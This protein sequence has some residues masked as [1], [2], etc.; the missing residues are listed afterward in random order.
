MKHKVCFFAQ[1]LIRVGERMEIRVDSNEVGIKVLDPISN[2]ILDSQ[3]FPAI[4]SKI[5]E[6][7]DGSPD[8]S[9]QNDHST[10]CTR[11]LSF[12]SSDSESSDSEKLT[13]VEEN[14]NPTPV[15]KNM[16]V[17]N[18][19]SVEEA[20]NME[21]PNPPLVGEAQNLEVPNPP[22]VGEAKNMELKNPTSVGE[23]KNMELKNPTPHARRTYLKGLSPKFNGTQ[24][25]KNP[26]LRLVAEVEN[27]AMQEGYPLTPEEIICL[28]TG[29]PADIRKMWG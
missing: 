10:K 21:V 6:L 18:P 27:L 29:T 14:V 16:K 20:Q 22:L 2:S 11:K 26:R 8:H 3:N 19:I 12:E 17:A 15:T 25:L 7:M 4:T 24:R 1:L 5:T 13:D 28:K 23:S 9:T